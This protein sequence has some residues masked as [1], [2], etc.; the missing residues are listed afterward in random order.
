MIIDGHN[1]AFSK[2]VKLQVCNIFTMSQ[3]KL[4]MEFIF[5]MQINKISTSLIIAFDESSQTCLK[6]PK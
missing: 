3:K 6:Y 4:G 2:Y 5:C 1:Q